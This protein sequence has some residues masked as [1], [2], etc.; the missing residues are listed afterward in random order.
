MWNCSKS[1]RIEKV[2]FKWGLLGLMR[3]ITDRY[4]YHFIVP[5][6]YDM[7]Y[8]VLSVWYC[9]YL[10]LFES[11]V[12]FRFLFR[13]GRSFRD[14][15]LWKLK[16]GSVT[17]KVSD[18]KII[19]FKATF[20]PRAK[21]NVHWKSI[22]VCMSIKLRSPVFI[23]PSLKI[24]GKWIC[25]GSCAHSCKIVAIRKILSRDR[26]ATIRIELKVVY[27]GRTKTCSAFIFPFSY[28]LSKRMT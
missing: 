2:Q 16:L 17:L 10:C 11:L 28:N 23:D 26:R 25:M 3:L 6:F 15:A 21:S 27:L 18:N 13:T 24:N 19:M 9:N 20:E 22:V 8:G 4:F 14:P 7:F 5:P 1:L 12:L